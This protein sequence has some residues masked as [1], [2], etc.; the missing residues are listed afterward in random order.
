MNTNK[1]VRLDLSITP[2]F[3]RVLI[4]LG[5]TLEIDRAEVIYRAVA[6]LKAAV[7]A[8]THGQA[9]GAADSPDALETEFV[10]F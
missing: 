8:R 10:G 4:G 7:E 1:S 3:D 2:E 6:L 9:I 5:A